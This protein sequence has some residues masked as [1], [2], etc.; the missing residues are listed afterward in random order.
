MKRNGTRKMHSFKG[1][2]NPNFGKF[3]VEISEGELKKIYLADKL[4][5]VEI[6]RRIG[7]HP[8]TIIH[9]LDRF[10]IPKRSR[11]EAISI[12][13]KRDWKNPTYRKNVIKSL[14]RKVFSKE[15]REKI[16]VAMKKRFLNPVFKSK[17]IERLSK[18]WSPPPALFQ[19]RPNKQEQKLIGFL[20]EHNFPFEY[21]GDG[22]VV[23][24][25]YCP[26]F[27]DCNGSKKIIELFGS[28]W[29]TP[30]DIEVREKTYG[31]YGFQML[32]VWDNELS[33]KKAL[34]DKISSFCGDGSNG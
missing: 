14:K 31:K 13:R 11:S 21:V 24:E 8:K 23:I 28:Y 20:D 25:R 5:T 26:D 9:Y 32:V 10:N 1:E 7:V 6:G 34:L 12:A 15:Q 33:D 22:K 3:K 30:E 27:I 16:S 29:H 2:N 4:S 19:K 17:V 18:F